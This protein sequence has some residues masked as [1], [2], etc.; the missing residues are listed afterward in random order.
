MEGSHLFMSRSMPK[1]ALI[2]L[3][4]SVSY[5]LVVLDTSVVNVA[6]PRIGASVAA[7]ISG[8]QWVVN[9]YL[10]VFASFLLSG[11]A[12]C[13]RFGA[14]RVFT[15]GLSLFVG[16]SA[17]CG[18]SSSIQ[19]L[20]LGRAL[21]GFGGALLVPSSLSL[22]TQIYDDLVARSRAISTWASWG[23]IALVMGPLAGGVV[24]ELL[25]W[26]SIFFINVPLGMVGI[27]IALRI[28]T[29]RPRSRRRRFDLAGQSAAVISAFSLIASL[30]EGPSYGWTSPL[31]LGGLCLSII[32]GAVFIAVEARTRDPMLPL[33]V[34]RDRN[35]GGIAYIF[36]A[37]SIS[38]MGT[39]FVL[40]FYFQ[41]MRAFSALQTG[42]ALFPL[43]S[44]VV[45]GNKI[46]GHL[47][48]RMTPRRIMLVGDCLKGAGFLGL[49]LVRVGA[50]YSLLIVPF[51][52]IGLGAGLCTPMYTSLFMSSVDRAFAGVASGVSRATGQIGAAFGVA[53]MGALIADRHRFIAHMT[54][55]T[56]ITVAL[57]MSVLF[58][59]QRVLQ[60][61]GGAESDA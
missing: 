37:A 40:T 59:I 61:L 30:I 20:L 21:Q 36:F 44:C 42:F 8:L 9:V 43:C 26:R 13:D 25:D 27:G 54:V 41:E 10:L 3:A 50:S 6:L 7:D 39:L 12:L 38:F 56:L 5:V 28:K 29:E 18:L 24:I 51:C 17:L 1:D 22:I 15:I 53:V 33:S 2:L 34:F 14:E 47:V 49:L 11:G 19:Q 4:T 58:V 32:A 48:A 31:I 16:A 52:L 46:A 57:S 35:V 55:S 60:D 23:G 45:L